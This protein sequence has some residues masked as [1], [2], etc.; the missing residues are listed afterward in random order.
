[1][2]FLEVS[3][4]SHSPTYPKAE[5]RI[6]VMDSVVWHFFFLFFQAESIMP[7]SLLTIL[8]KSRKQFGQGRVAAG[9]GF[10]PAALSR[11]SCA[12][13]GHRPPLLQERLQMDLGRGCSSHT[14]QNHAMGY[15][16][17]QFSSGRCEQWKKG[18]GGGRAVPWE[19]LCP[20]RHWHHQVWLCSGLWVNSDSTDLQN[21]SQILLLQQTLPKITPL[22]LYNHAR[23]LIHW[24][25]TIIRL[26]IRHNA[27]NS[28]HSFWSL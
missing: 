20:A 28:H 21:L 26:I 10:F 3:F 27:L 6:S 7:I 9:I 12:L 23:C 19:S 1:M 17:S 25:D 8:P 13:W 14:T 15:L 18:E 5:R 4:L 2:K 22:S 24:L 16:L 11:A